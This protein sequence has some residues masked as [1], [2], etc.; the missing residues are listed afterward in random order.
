MPNRKYMSAVL[1]VVALALQGINCGSNSNPNRLLKSIAV[2][3]ST[4]DARDYMS[5]QVPFTATG[6]FSMPPSP[7]V[8]NFSTPYLGGFTVDPSLATIVS[9]SAGT[10]TVQC[11][12]G[13]SGTTDVTASACVYARGTTQ[14]CVPVTSSAKLTCP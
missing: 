8:L 10:A 4:A 2:T 5:G 1:F 13:A 6:T 12:A 3:P 14:T 7:A 9:S 11:V